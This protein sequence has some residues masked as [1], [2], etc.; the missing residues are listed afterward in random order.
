MKETFVI[1]VPETPLKKV[2]PNEIKKAAI[3]TTY[4]TGNAPLIKVTS[5]V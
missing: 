3:L 4:K 1:P 2:N 5:L